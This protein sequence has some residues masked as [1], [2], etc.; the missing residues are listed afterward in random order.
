M[1]NFAEFL[2]TIVDH[3][4]TD[5]SVER[6]RLLIN[7][8]RQAERWFKVELMTVLDRA[9]CVTSWWPEVSYDWDTRKKC[10]FV[11]RLSPGERPELIGIELKALFIGMQRR[12]RLVPADAACTVRV[13]DSW[14]CT[15]EGYLQEGG[16]LADAARLCSSRCFDQRICLVFAYGS[17][18]AL[19]EG[20][21]QAFADGLEQM[22]AALPAPLQ[23]AP[24]EGPGGATIAVGDTTHLRIAAYEAAPTA[25]AVP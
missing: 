2:P 15:L 1:A 22:A 19:N 24:V 11:A 17:A 6:L 16:V 10:D 23:I 12:R 5:P 13:E 4:A 7:K 18:P 21:M 3:F 8:D 25:G 9:S 20:A 14:D